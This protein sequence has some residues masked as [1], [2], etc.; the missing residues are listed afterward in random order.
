MFTA[1]LDTK[2]AALAPRATEEILPPPAPSREGN[3][4][5]LTWQVSVDRMLVHTKQRNLAVPRVSGEPTAQSATHVRG[6]Q[7]CKHPEV[8]EEQ[9]LR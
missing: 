9:L 4:S 3:P 7:L 5:A 1:C 2:A 6:I 8:P